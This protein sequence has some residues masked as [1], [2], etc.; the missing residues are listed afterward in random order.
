MH[1]AFLQN[2]VSVNLGTKIMCFL[3]CRQLNW[4]CKMTR[5]LRVCNEKSSVWKPLSG[6]NSVRMELLCH[7]TCYHLKYLLC[8]PD[9]AMLKN[10]E[11]F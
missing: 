10:I 3:A 2:A 1:T 6:V 11:F 9:I 4:K 7:L 5:T 8:H